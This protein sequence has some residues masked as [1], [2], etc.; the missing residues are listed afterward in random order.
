LSRSGEAWA[1]GHPPSVRSFE[2][3]LLPRDCYAAQRA[4][5][6]AIVGL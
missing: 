3:Q 1:D 4:N 5:A 6:G 2:E